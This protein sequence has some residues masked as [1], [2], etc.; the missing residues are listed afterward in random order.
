MSTWSS[1]KLGILLSGLAISGYAQVQTKNNFV[2]TWE[3]SSSWVSGSQPNPLLTGINDDIRVRGYITVNSPLDF[4]GNNETKS[5]IIYDTLVVRGNVHF[6][7]KAMDL[8]VEE[9][10]LLV[11]FGDFSA[12]NKI[13]IANGG[14]MVV[15]K[16]MSF[17]PSGQDSF[18][19]TETGTLY[20]D[21]T[22]SGNGNADAIDKPIEALNG[23]PNY[24]EQELFDFISGGGS[25]P[26]P[27]TLNYFRGVENSG[28]IMLRWE[29]LTEKNFDFFEVQRSKNGQDFAVIG[30]VRGNGFTST[31]HQ[32]SFTD[33]T[34]L[35]G[36][37]FY[38]LRAVDYDGSS[39][40]FQVLR[41]EIKPD[42]QDVRL[43]PN[44]SSGDGFRLSIPHELLKD[45]LTV[46]L[47]DLSGSTLFF[48]HVGEPEINATLD[49]VLTPGTYLVMLEVAGYLE[50]YRLVVIN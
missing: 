25:T 28:Q 20:V 14:T 30:E 38:R 22:I 17:S 24:G 39:E 9:G 37:N 33:T 29:T 48:T 34:P 2:G 12:T 46:R 16:N 47:T 5:I 27:I 49:S 13:S 21:G 35:R 40:I 43:Y 41:F 23:S 1:I 44:P 50:T 26:L 10:G 3:S 6:N 32:Y 42:F 7:N 8:I 45:A 11:V 18:T 31:P 4:A 15:T 36:L 19:N